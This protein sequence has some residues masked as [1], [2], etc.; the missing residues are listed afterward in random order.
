MTVGKSKFPTVATLRDGGWFPGAWT[1][2]VPLHLGHVREFF[3]FPTI[4]NGTRSH[5][6]VPVV[7]KRATAWPIPR[8][9]LRFPRDGVSRSRH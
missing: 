9:C 4:K 2:R 8:I 3:M 7:V 5:T 1:I 6:V